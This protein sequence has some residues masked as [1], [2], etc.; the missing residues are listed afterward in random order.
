MVFTPLRQF[1]SKL[2]LP[3]PSHPHQN[4]SYTLLVDHKLKEPSLLPTLNRTRSHIRAPAEDYP[5][6]AQVVECV[7]T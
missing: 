2:G 4:R 6:R 7:H 1:R 5:P 3:A